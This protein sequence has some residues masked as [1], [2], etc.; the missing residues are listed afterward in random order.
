MPMRIAAGYEAL[1]EEVLAAVAMRA[2]VQA[3]WRLIRGNLH[4]SDLTDSTMNIVLNHFELRSRS[5]TWM[6]Q[7]QLAH[8]DHQ[9]EAIIHPAGAALKRCFK[10]GSLEAE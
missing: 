8:W 4:S 6:V 5:L 3:G 7:S 1:A 2:E 9:P 10:R